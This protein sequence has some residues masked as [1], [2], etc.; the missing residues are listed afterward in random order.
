MTFAK[1]LES[2]LANE[3]E[4]MFIAEDTGVSL[5]EIQD[6]DTLKQHMYKLGSRHPM[7]KKLADLHAKKAAIMARQAKKADSMKAVA[8]GF[9]YRP[10]KGN[11]LV[12]KKTGHVLHIGPN[13][14]WSHT[15]AGDKRSYNGTAIRGLKSHLGKLHS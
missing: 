8:H 4:E 9:G 11:V 15:K 10:A 7:H 14:S 13:N 5:N 2:A 1:K 12:H 3:L 6:L